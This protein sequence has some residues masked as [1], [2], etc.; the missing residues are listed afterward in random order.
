MK[1][2]KFHFKASRALLAMTLL[3]VAVA[4][5]L[6]LP[7]VKAAATGADAKAQT[8]AGASLPMG[9][10]ARVNGSSITRDELSWATNAWLRNQGMD[11]GGV[12]SP[13]SYKSLERQVLER[14]IQEELILQAADSQGLAIDEARIDARIAEEQARHGSAEEFTDR[15][16]SFEMTMAEHRKRTQRQLLLEEYVRVNIQPRVEIDQARV[17]EVYADY[18]EE[19]Q[20]E[21]RPESEA[22]ML[23]R[24][25]L[26]RQ[27]LA[28]L[29][30][31]HLQTLMENSE[32][33]AGMS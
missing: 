20:D 13:A 15:L 24:D 9:V 1:I 18:L 5:L 21:A 29:I 26:A 27:L 28:E 7:A 31:E 12:R 19:Q 17:D 23:I 8:S 3:V 32:I 16:R 11:L 4:L 10:V 33:Q 25:Q 22:K 14:L 2:P 6:G 30:G